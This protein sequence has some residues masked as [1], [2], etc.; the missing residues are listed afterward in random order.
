MTNVT[1][2]K[3]DNEIRLERIV[4]HSKTSRD[5]WKFGLITPN[6]RAWPRVHKTYRK[7]GTKGWGYET[8]RWWDANRLSSVL[9]GRAEKCRRRGVHK[10][11]T[12]GGRTHRLYAQ[13]KRRRRQICR[14]AFFRVRMTLGLGP[15]SRA[16]QTWRTLDGNG[17]ASGPP[18]GDANAIGPTCTRVGFS[19]LSKVLFQIVGVQIDVHAV[20]HFCH[21]IPVAALGDR[22]PRRQHG[23]T[24]QSAIV[25]FGWGARG[26]EIF[27]VYKGRC[28]RL[29]GIV[30]WGDGGTYSVCG[31]VIKNYPSLR[32]D[33]SIENRL[34]FGED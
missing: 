14:R 16:R 27:V 17:V 32:K 31:R 33:R 34:Y 29:T 3:L 2:W 6:H 7:N 21:V 9:C 5:W 25:A 13:I 28:R 1:L 30:D 22:E 12:T 11:A 4:M 20:G 19:Y 23:C 18:D 24:H 8:G 26:A 15:V 10:I